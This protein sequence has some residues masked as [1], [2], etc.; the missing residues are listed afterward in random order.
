MCMGTVFF[1]CY[2]LK[3]GVV[4][5]STFMMTLGLLGVVFHPLMPYSAQDMGQFL[6]I[7]AYTFFLMVRSLS[8]FCVD[9]E[10]WC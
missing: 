6:I 8:H 5:L 1:C 9:M 3:T 10:Y 7:Y 2:P 4:I